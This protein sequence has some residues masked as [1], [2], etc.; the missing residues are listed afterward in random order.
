MNIFLQDATRQNTAHKIVII[1]LKEKRGKKNIN[2][3][4]VLKIL[5]V[6][7]VII[8]NIA[9]KNALENQITKILNQIIQLSERL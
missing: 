5:S 3:S 7:L 4:I 8:E 9:P 6:M 2:A 1:F